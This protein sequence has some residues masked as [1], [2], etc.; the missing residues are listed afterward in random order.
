MTHFTKPTRSA[1]LDQVEMGFAVRQ[2]VL[3]LV[4][5]GKK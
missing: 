3:E 4:L 5:G 1:I 2:A